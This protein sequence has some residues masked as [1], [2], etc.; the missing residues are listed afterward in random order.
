MATGALS[1]QPVVVARQD[2]PD[3]TLR[4]V[5]DNGNT[6]S[7]S[8]FHRFWRA[9]LG[10]AMARDLK[11][12]DVLRTL[13]GPARVASVNRASV[14]P[15]FSIGVAGPRTYFVG[16]S[17][18]LVHDETLPPSHPIEPPFDRIVEP[19]APGHP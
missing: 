11:P 14:Q 13:A 19:T 15:V 6:V 10:W 7:Q 3:Q 4:V 18:M 5:L 1:F 16:G 17:A 8:P 9:G 2:P 12:G